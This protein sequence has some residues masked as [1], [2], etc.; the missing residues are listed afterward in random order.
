MTLNLQS[1]IY[2]TKKILP[3]MVERKDRVLIFLA[4]IAGVR[5]NKN[6]GL[7]GISKAGVIQLARNLAVE[8]GSHNTTCQ[9]HFTK[10]D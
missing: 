4:S 2:L 3:Q 1:A 5:G 8:F 10:H 9:R 7:Y 6:I